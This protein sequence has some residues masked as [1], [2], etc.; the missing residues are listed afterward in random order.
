[1]YEVTTRVGLEQVG[2]DGK[3]QY[4]AILCEMVNCGCFQTQDL[5]YDIREMTK[6]H[7]GWF[8]VSWQVR[9]HRMPKLCEKLT[10]RTY[11]YGFSGFIGKR[12]FAILSESGET[13]VTAN[14]LWTWMDLENARP[15]R[16]PKEFYE[17]F[18]QDD[19]PAEEWPGRKLRVPDSMEEQFSF[20]VSPM[21]LDTN[22]HMNNSYYVMAAARCIPEGREAKALFV[23]YRKQAMPDA[24]VMVKSAVTEDV[25]FV[26][27]CDEDDDIYSVVKFEL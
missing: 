13:L 4:D 24:R 7:R 2:P 22:G 9:I 3:I 17:R 21:F 15:V 20:T 1:M 19:P 10:V 25:V 18:G 8:V 23:E 16:I 5:V 6:N 12:H 11:P 14:S 27:L 26:T